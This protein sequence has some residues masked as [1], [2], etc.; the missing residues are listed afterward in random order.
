[1]GMERLVMLLPDSA[2]GRGARPD[3][4][5]APVG[6]PSKVP[7]ALAARTLRR[8]GHSVILESSGKSL[9]SHM[10]RSGKL[11]ARRVLIVGESE[12]ASGVF[13]LKDLKTGV[14]RPVT[15]GELSKIGAAD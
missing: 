5:V 9:Q 12:L 13:Q 6:P 3:I 7:A 1:M 8:A 2:Q 10:R 4:L 11:G 15:A 14:Q